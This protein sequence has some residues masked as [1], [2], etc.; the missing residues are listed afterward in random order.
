MET[1]AGGLVR[2]YDTNADGRPDYFT[3]Q[4]GGGRVVRI[5]Y[6]T[7]GDGK[8]GESIRL[9][10][11]PISAC[12]HVI[13]ILDGVGYET[14]DAFRREG[15]LRLFHPPVRLISTFPAMTDLAL[16]DVFRSAPAVG[17]E[18]VH[19][20]RRTNRLAGGDADYLGMKNE[21]WAKELAYRAGMVWDPLAYLY[22][23]AV[24]NRE[25]AEFRKVFD[26]HDRMEIPVYFVA[27]AGLATRQGS[28]GQ[29]RVLDAID[30]LVEEL[31]RETRGMLKVTLLSDHGHALV[32]AERIDFRT[33]LGGKG[34]RAA[35]RLDGPR[36][37]A[38]IEY[39]L[40]TYASFATRDPPA[41]AAA[42]L[43]HPGVD[44]VTYREGE[45]VVVERP[46]AK[47]LIERR[48]SRYRYR[49]VQGDPL[50]LAPIIEKMAAEKLVDADGFAEDAA[51]FA[52]TLTHRYPDCVDRLWRAFNGLVENPPD[53]VASLK[54]GYCA[55]LASRAAW[56]P[57]VASTHGDLERKS[58]T[59]FIMST[60]GPLMPP[61][62][63][64]RHRDVP[65]IM[66]RLEGREWPPSFQGGDK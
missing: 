47:A 15:G 4:D 64:A 42:L 18:V 29:R 55:G 7:N 22:P 8:P 31:V 39:G 57:Y 56:L 36:D 13:I 43:E 5:A 20:D 51:W 50:T 46:G 60:A 63:G 16:A 48:G 49:Q 32:R 38:V 28:D 2:A 1:T 9:D 37:V 45:T 26:R 58:S 24:F 3:T 62:T 17:Y 53:V 27:T 41:L 11:L 14:V 30:R 59:A 19:F 44:L 6:D 52:R 34:W 21:A 33:Y 54:D 40:I 25:L 12:R 23:G 61:E 10:D 66:K 65:G 35:D